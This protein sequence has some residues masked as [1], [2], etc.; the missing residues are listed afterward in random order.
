ME[1]EVRQ[2]LRSSCQARSMQ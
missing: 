1:A 2:D